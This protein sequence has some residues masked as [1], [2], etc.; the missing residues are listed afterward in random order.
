MSKVKIGFI[1]KNENNFILLNC[2]LL[3]ATLFII[4]DHFIES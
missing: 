4:Y 2:L 1:E 3:L